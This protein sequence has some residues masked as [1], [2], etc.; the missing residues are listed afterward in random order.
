MM[1]M[2]NHP[3]QLR[4]AV[5]ESVWRKIEELGVA[6]FPLPARGRIP[7]FKGAEEAARR[8]ISLP[9]AASAR[10][11]FVNPDSPQAPLRR[12]LLEKGVLV[13]VSTP[14]ISSGFILLDPRRIPRGLYHWASTIKGM[15]KLGEKVHPSALPRIDMFIAGSVAVNRMGARLG[16]GEGYSELEYGILTHYERLNEKTPIATTVHDIQVVD[17]D[18]PLKPWD[19]TV[20]IVATPTRVLRREGPL[21]RPR[22]IMCGLLDAGKLREIGLLA[23]ICRG[24]MA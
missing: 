14:R 10:V 13:V 3:D 8:L 19:F 18:I 24:D 12:M 16:K 9:E 2:G 11:V 4:Q 7:N 23:E 22:G 17:V 1:D 20:D 6:D 21:R 5:R 15:V